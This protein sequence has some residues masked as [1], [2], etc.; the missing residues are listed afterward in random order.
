[1]DAIEDCFFPAR[2]LARRFKFLGSSGAS[3]LLAAAAR[4]VWAHIVHRI[5]LTFGP[6]GA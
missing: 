2:E 4:G 6:R 3:R 1:M 5:G